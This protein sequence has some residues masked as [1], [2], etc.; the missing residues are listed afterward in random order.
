MLPGVLALVLVA[1]AGAL[2]QQA[3]ATALRGPEL[4]AALRAGGYILYF[5]HADTDHRQ[6]DDRMSLEDCATQ[7]NLTDR[8]R[9]HSR[10][11]GEAIRAL[12]I[13]IGAVL[14]S[15]LCRTVETAPLAFGSA[16][17]TP[18]VREGGPLPP[19]SPGRFPALRAL[20]STPVPPGA[21]T[22]IVGHAYP[23]YALVGGQYLSGGEADVVRPG[24]GDFQVMA[25][26]ALRQWRDLAAPAVNR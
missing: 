21:N 2:A 25:R 26:V 18:A 20:L 6:N 15:P 5:R 10:A 11:I 1:P 8:G 12:G 24:G 14:A 7:R 22:V 9:D 17:K 19:G 23:Y 4:L 3:S 13:P 16:R